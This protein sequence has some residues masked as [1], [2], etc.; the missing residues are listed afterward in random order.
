[1]A[2]AVAAQ[3]DALEVQ[4][5]PQLQQPH[6]QQKQQGYTR[7]RAKRNARQWADEST[8]S[9]GL[10]TLTEKSQIAGAA[11]CVAA[12]FLNTVSVPARTWWWLLLP[13][14]PR[15]VQLTAPG[16]DNGLRT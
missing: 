9:T 8:P 16:T 13:L 6:Q 15:C 11:A 4:P 3:D 1:V 5:Q 7:Q 10:V 14:L 2:A 12:D